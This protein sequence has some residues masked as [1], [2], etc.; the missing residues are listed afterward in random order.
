MICE[1]HI[2]RKANATQRRAPTSSPSGWK[3]NAVKLS[4]ACALRQRLGNQGAQAFAARAAR[5]ATSGPALTSEGTAGQL[6]I[7]Q[8]RDVQER[9]AE[10]V[11]DVVMRV[12]ELASMPSNSSPLAVGSAGAVVQRLCADCEEESGESQGSEKGSRRR[13]AASHPG[14]GNR[15]QRA[16]WWWQPIACVDPRILRAAL[17]SGPQSGTGALR[18]ACCRHRELDKCE[19]LH[20]RAGHRFQRRSIRA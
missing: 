13:Y 10:R 6:S 17:W 14:G 19:G 18:R 4:G 5:S 1:P 3:S 16:P 11:A 12:P 7:S 20:C 9:E 2:E 8:P 15:Y